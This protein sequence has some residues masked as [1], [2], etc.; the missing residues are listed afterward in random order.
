MKALLTI[1]GIFIIIISGATSAYALDWPVWPDSATHQIWAHYGMY[2]SNSNLHNGIDI[3][4]PNMTPVFAIEAGYVKAIITINEGFSFWRVV[5]ADSAGTQECDGWMYAHVHPNYLTVSVGD[6]VEAGNEI[7]KIVYWPGYPSTTEEHLHLSKIR[8]EGD[9]TAWANGFSEG[10]EF[11]NNPMDLFD[12]KNINDTTPPVFE[13]AWGNQLFAFCENQ[14]INYFNEGEPVSGYIDIIA[15]IY[16]YHD[17]YLLKDTPLKIEYK[18][19][20]DS[21]LQWQ[22]LVTFDEPFGT[23]KDVANY[24]KIMYQDDYF[25]NSENYGPDSQVFYFNLTNTNNDGICEQSDKLLSW[26]TPYFKNG[27]YKIFCRAT[28]YSGNSMTDSMLIGVENAFEISGLVSLPE[29]KLGIEGVIVT[30]LVNG[31]CDTTDES[32]YYL[33]PDASGGTQTIHFE[34]GGYA[35][36]DTTLMIHENNEINARMAFNFLCGDANGNGAINIIDITYLISF[37]YKSGPAPI[38]VEAGDAN[39]NGVINILDITYLIS[40]L[41]KSGPDPICP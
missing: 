19:E 41:Y 14:V 34:K 29:E 30:A 21:S 35:S 38:P 12:N 23:Y 31:A 22:T 5:I 25:C 40:F 18:I 6:Y 26:E 32:G 11:I 37:L 4:A 24:M 27:E 36:F 39:G 9:S 7:S 28:D 1:I 20:G 16:D 13:N 33:I 17:Y 15:R 10:W 3:L 8:F 2:Q